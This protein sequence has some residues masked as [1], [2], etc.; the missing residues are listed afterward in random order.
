M[1]YNLQESA[2]EY[3]RTN[4]PHETDLSVKTTDIVSGVV[5]IGGGNSNYEVVVDV[6]TLEVLYCEKRL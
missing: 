3:V 5:T 1:E 2:V 6:T 4:Y